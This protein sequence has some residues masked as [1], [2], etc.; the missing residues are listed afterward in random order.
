[1]KRALLLALPLACSSSSPTQRP[2]GDDT[3]PITENV[4][5]T[6]LAGPVDAV[7]DEYGMIHIYATSV[8]DAMRVMGYQMGRDRHVQLELIRRTAE[9]RMAAL[10]GHCVP[11]QLAAS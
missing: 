8:G 6:G 5:V 4:S 9:G 2:L 3:V 1:M 10:P 7:R 11:P